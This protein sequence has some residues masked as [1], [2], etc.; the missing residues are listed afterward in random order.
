MAQTLSVELLERLEAR[1]CA[2]GAQP[3][4]GS[5]PGLSTDEIR[6]LAAA[7]GFP[8]PVPAE[9]QLWWSWRS[10]GQ[11]YILPGTQYA[12]LAHN[13]Q[14]YEFRRQWAHEHGISPQMPDVV[15]DDWWHPLWLPIFVIDGGIVLV[16][17]A[18]DS[19]GITTPI[20]EVDGQS[21]GG[22][23][24]ARIVASSLGDYVAQMLDAIDAGAYRYQPDV[25]D[26]SPAS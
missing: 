19:D 4:K 8:G 11:G 13:L 16:L 24:F 23:Y 10:W 22:S 9:G 17:D 15:A 12:P 2:D 1:L 21:F 20:R 6:E 25:H 5:R 7:A 14:E 18:S 3:I 26:W